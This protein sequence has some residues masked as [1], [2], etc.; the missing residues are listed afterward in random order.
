MEDAGPE[1]L[2]RA[3]ERLGEIA[4]APED[5]RALVHLLADP[6]P[7]KTLRHAQAIT[8]RILF[9]LWRRC[10][11]ICAEAGGVAL[12]VTPA[13]AA[14]LAEA[15]AVLASTPDARP[16]GPAR[17]GLEV[18]SRRPGRCSAWWLTISA[19]KLPPPPHPGTERLRP[20]ET[21]AAIRDA[22]R[23]YRNCLANYVDH[24]VRPASASTTNGYRRRAR[25]S[26]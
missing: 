12:R 8:P 18:A 14:L 7:A 9:A 17:G 21:A 19:A 4:W 10:R 13:Q 2:R 22:A 25:W 20:L 26:S 5:Y 15:H 16:A 23:R 11:Q 3:L 1:G 6:A 24:A